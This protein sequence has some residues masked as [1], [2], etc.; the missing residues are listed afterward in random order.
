MSSRIGSINVVF[1]AKFA[2]WGLCSMVFCVEFDGKRYED[3]VQLRHGEAQHVEVLQAEARAS[4]ESLRES[5]DVDEALQTAQA[6]IAAQRRVLEKQL[7]Q[8]QTRVDARH[9]HQWLAQP[10]AQQTLAHPRG[11]GAVQEAEKTGG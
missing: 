11:E 5:F 10:A 7:N 2:A 9:G 8:V 6:K 1:S 3:S 4:L